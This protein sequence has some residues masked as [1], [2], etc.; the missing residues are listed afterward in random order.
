MENGNVNSA[1]TKK[2]VCSLPAEEVARVKG[3]GCLWDKR[4]EDRFN[5]RVITVNGKLTGDKLAA[6]AEAAK[7]FG[8]SEAAMT[9]RLTIEIQ[10]VPYANIEP[11]RAFLAEHG[12]QTGGTGPKV[13]PVVS[14]KGTTCQYGL[15]DTF[16]LSEQ[17]HTLFYE[18]YHHVRLPH[19]FKIAVGGCP[20]NCVKP[21]LNDL[22][23]VGQ[24][25]PVLD[26]DACKG[27][28]KCQPEAACPIHIAH[29]KD[30]KLEIDPARCIGCGRCV[31]KCPFHV[32]DQFVGGYRVYLGGRWGK[33]F[34][35]GKP[36]AKLFTEEAEV[37]SVV[38]KTILLF[39]DKGIAGERLS[40]TLERI[41][42]EEACR[43]LESDDL[44]QRKEEIL[45][46]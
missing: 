25:L 46:K 3:L 19:K 22:G 10:G 4:S 8:S 32:T 15:I 39:R 38:E 27:C 18:G 26:L 40:D 9:S 5:V 28:K 30:G 29:V 20:N 37:L 36:M 44:L 14:C 16:G 41:G 42:F 24:K 7:R 13:R 31:G 6:I 17:I 21:S 11:M 1:E 23:I 35:H 45:N 34:A 12:L 33:S 2:V 43:L